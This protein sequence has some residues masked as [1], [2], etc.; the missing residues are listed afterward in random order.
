VCEAGVLTEKVPHGL[1][2]FLQP[3]LDHWVSQY[4]M[5]VR[6]GSYKTLRSNEDAYHLPGFHDVILATSARHWVDRGLEK[7]KEMKRPIKLMGAAL[8]V[9]HEI[10]KSEARISLK[11]REMEARFQKE[12]DEFFTVEQAKIRDSFDSLS[13]ILNLDIVKEQYILDISYLQD[14]GEAFL[15]VMLPGEEMMLENRIMRL[16]KEQEN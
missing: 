2:V 3:D 7:E 1:R 16:G 8:E 9:A 11:K 5:G 14:F 12:W 13:L 4:W 15:R 6:G 10:S